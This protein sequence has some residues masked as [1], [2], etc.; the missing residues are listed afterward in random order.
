MT[1]HIEQNQKMVQFGQNPGYS[2]RPPVVIWRSCPV[3][4]SASSCYNI[5]S[6]WKRILTIFC[7]Q[8]V[9]S[10]SEGAQQALEEVYHKVI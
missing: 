1:A 4:K 5:H 8:L 3:A 10:G 9:G 2:M 6:A 7:K